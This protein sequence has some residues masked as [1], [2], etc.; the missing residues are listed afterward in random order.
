MDTPTP[1]TVVEPCH[2]YGAA[3]E[4]PV[5]GRGTVAGEQQDR[6]PLCADCLD[7]L[8]GNPEAFWLPLRQGRGA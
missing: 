3:A 6:V 5:V 4:L 1:H 2:R 7:L 8:L